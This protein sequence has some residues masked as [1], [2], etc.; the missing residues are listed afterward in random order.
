M[1]TSAL[2]CG[3]PVVRDQGASGMWQGGA[4]GGGPV[5]PF[6]AWSMELAGLSCRQWGPT[7]VCKLVLVVESS[8]WE[9]SGGNRRCPGPGRLLSG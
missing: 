5:G 9:K 4:G 1:P 8:L 2:R 3:V 6:G 7:G